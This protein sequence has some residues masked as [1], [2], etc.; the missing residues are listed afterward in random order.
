LLSDFIISSDFFN[1]VLVKNDFMT[2]KLGLSAQSIT[3][4][5]DSNTAITVGSGSLPVFATPSMVALMENAAV[6]CLADFLDKAQT[7]V[8]ILLNVEHIRA[9]G[10]GEKIVAKA[11]FAEINDRE[12]LFTVEAYDSKGLTGKGIHKRFIVNAEKFMRKLK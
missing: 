12:L 8:G 9:S 1:F 3:T 7:S 2:T 4:V 10:I 5:D 11:T 6:K